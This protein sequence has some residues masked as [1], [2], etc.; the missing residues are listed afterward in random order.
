MTMPLVGVGVPVWRGSAFVAET[1]QSVLAQRDVRLQV[2]I[3]VDGADTDSEKVCQCFLS[4][5]RVR[6]VMQ[7]RRLGWVNNTAAALAGAAAEGAAY[8][9]LQPHDDLIEPDYLASLIEVA[10]ANPGAAVVFS[11][12]MAFGDIGGVLSQPSVE[13]SP[14]QRQID[15][16]VRHYNAVAYR[17]LN[18]VS[19]LTRVAAISGN[20]CENFACDTVWMARLARVG[21]LIRVPRVLYRKRF[22]RE[23]T[24]GMWTAWPSEQKID[25]WVQHCLDMLAEAL[26]VSTGRA[27]RR[28]IIDAARSRLLLKMCKLGPF[29]DEIGRMSWHQKGKMWRRFARSA[30]ARPDIGPLDN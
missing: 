13:G 25:A 24:H 23:S 30:A 6:L 27:D 16:L 11:D 2:F 22:H 4:D 1:L 7:P 10:E 18:R 12:L 26:P 14:L 8:V 21:D 9:C 17:G 28:L 29:Q 15:L 20:R 3:S 19:A 5:P